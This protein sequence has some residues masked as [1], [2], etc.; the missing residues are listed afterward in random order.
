LSAQ[1]ESY[2][3]IDNMK[4]NGKLTL[5]ENIGDL[6]GVAVAYRAYR[7]SL[8]GKE[9]PVIDGF[10]GDQRFFMGWAQV[11]RIKARD[12]ALRNQLLT[13]SHSPGRYRAFV[14]LTNF[15]PFYT[16]FDIKPGDKMYRAPEDRVKV[17]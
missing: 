5:G 17:W 11:W 1:Y 2:N 6:S 9:A 3:P 8:Q 16:A 13:D 15:D 12:A 10:T 7:I 4:I 14:P